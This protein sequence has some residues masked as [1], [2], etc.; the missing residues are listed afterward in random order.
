MG[1]VLL[2]PRDLGTLELIVRRP[3]TDE[4]EILTEGELSPEGG[5]VGDN[6]KARGSMG[7][8]VS[9]EQ[10]ERQITIMNSRLI[11]L[12]TGDRR[13][14]SLAGDQLYMDLDLSRANLPPG[15]RLAVGSAILEITNAPHAGC[16]KFS[17]RFGLEALKF[18]SEPSRKDLRLRGIYARVVQPGLIRVGDRVQKLFSL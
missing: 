12:L 10:V 7:A 5:L 14:W 1:R 6:W 17:A 9:P 18:I 3:Q 4:R 15:T 11:D 16:K 2:S 8:P 13:F